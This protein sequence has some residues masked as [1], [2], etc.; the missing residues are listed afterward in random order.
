MEEDISI[1]Q[2]IEESYGTAKE[3]GWWEDGES[4][5]HRSPGTMMM[6]MVTELAEAF[7]EIRNGRS[8]QEI[9]YREDGKP[10]GVPAE[11]ADVLI[12]I[13][14]YCGGHDIPLLQALREKLAFN[15]T[16]P[17]RHGGKVA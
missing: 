13:A 6:L 15:K 3:K 10:E 8:L 9:W 4:E 14:D 16:R 12:R 7:E 17:Y 2:L 11:F 5:A 1:L